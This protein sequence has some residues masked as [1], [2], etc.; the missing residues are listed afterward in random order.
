MTSRSRLKMV[1]SSRS[2]GGFHGVRA[3]SGV[4]LAMRWTMLEKVLGVTALSDRLCFTAMFL[5]W[6]IWMGCLV[7]NSDLGPAVVQIRG[8]VPCTALSCP[9]M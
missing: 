8:R 5:L 1:G 4:F 7:L 3:C 9:I 6:P 2:V